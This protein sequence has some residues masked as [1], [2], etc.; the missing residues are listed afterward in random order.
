MASV[1]AAVN[2][3]LNDLSH[4]H[5]HQGGAEGVG[6][7]LHTRYLHTSGVEELTGASRESHS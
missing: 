6:S 1:L 3:L 7:P 2:L 5:E 4:M